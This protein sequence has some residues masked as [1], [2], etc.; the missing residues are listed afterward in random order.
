VLLS[1][2]YERFGTLPR[3]APVMLGIAAGAAGMVIGTALTMVGRLKLA[4]EAIGCGL[5]AT[6]AAAWLRVPLPIIVVVLAPLS[7]TAA[8]WRAGLIG[9]GEAAR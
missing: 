6:V 8:L 7:I 2:L 9:R 1:L 5:L 3:V 4:P